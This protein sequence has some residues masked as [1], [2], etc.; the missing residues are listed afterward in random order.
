[1]IGHVICF[2]LVVRVCRG[3]G[4]LEV[5]G[6][7]CRTCRFAILSESVAPSGMIVVFRGRCGKVM[8]TDKV[9]F[10]GE[11]LDLEPRVV[12]DLRTKHFI[13]LENPCM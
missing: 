6:R 8:S 13:C 10:W 1:M 5:G 11:D 2:P 7:S 4:R 9:L 12:L 3:V